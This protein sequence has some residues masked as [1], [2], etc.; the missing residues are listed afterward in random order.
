MVIL[1]STHVTLRIF[2]N[3]GGRIR[4]EHDLSLEASSPHVV[5]VDKYA[6]SCELACE[7]CLGRAEASRPVLRGS[8]ANKRRCNSVTVTYLCSNPSKSPDRSRNASSPTYFYLQ[9]FC[10]LQ[11][12]SVKRR[13]AFTRKRTLVRSQHRPLLKV[14]F[15]RQNANARREVGTHTRPFLHQSVNRS[16]YFG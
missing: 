10:K 4:T 11:Q 16:P 5:G 14:S 7:M 3:S 2:C 1:R 9:V 15:C 12:A 6:L 13:T 8:A